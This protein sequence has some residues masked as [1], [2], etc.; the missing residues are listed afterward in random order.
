MKGLD[1]DI[2]AYQKYVKPAQDRTAA[3][4]SAKR[5]NRWSENW[6]GL[7][8]IL[9]AVISLAISILALRS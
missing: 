7:T 2:Y 4:K 5:K 3:F 1:K 8:G 6:I 9:I